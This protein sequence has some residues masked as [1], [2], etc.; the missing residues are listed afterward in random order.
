MTDQN[1]S[2]SYHHHIEYDIV[3]SSDLFD[4]QNSLLLSVGKQKKTRRFVVVD[5]NVY[6]LYS[7][8]IEHYF[9]LHQIDAKIIPVGAGESNKSIENYLALLGKLDEFPINRYGEPI[10][11]IG[12]GVVTDMA[13]FVASTYRRG[14]PHIK[15]PTTLMGYIDA[16][17][18][19][20]TGVNFNNH[21]NRVGAFAQPKK[22]ILDKT[23]FSTLPKRHILNG[24]GEIIKLAIICDL[25]LFE[26]LEQHGVA[27]IDSHFQDQKSDL[28]LE[29]S[30]SIMIEQ[31]QPNLYEANLERAVDFG[32]TFGPALE[33]ADDSELLHGEAVV[34]D[35]IISVIL[36]HLRNLL[37]SNDLNRILKLIS[38]LKLR[39]HCDW[40]SP[41]LL[42]QG[43]ED[44]TY[45]RD[46][47]QRAPLPTAI[48]EYVFVNDI[49][50]KELCLACEYF[51]KREG[52]I[53]CQQT[54]CQT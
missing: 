12:G 36:A 27:S 19:I 14:I 38:H 24:V 16:S 28:I 32:H 7:T 5:H 41:E 34:L 22:V 4:P 46:G 15:I 29:R 23:F 35:I 26:L 43:L 52:E 53:E 8:K 48:G 37:S 30:I 2:V 17:I 40:L 50:F 25:P 47:L 18:G 10:I 11:V 49:S 42:W 54:L 31:L 39:V 33:M 45:H 9:R 1:W 44:R 13:G 3:S 51:N 6:Q 20:K 21:K